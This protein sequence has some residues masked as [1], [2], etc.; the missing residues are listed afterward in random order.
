MQLFVSD[1]NSLV[2]KTIYSYDLVN[3]PSVILIYGPSGSGK[4]TM[5]EFLYQR[6]SNKKV[7]AEFINARAFAQRYAYAAQNN[8]LTSFR[9]RYRSP[10]LLFM[11]DLQLL[12]EKTKTI[13]E[14]FYTYEYI[15]E[16]EGKMIIC[17]EADF[18]ALGF[19][20]EGLASRFSGGL[21]LKIRQPSNE[22]I[23]RFIE[24]YL[25]SRNLYMEQ[26]V[27]SALTGMECNLQM[28]VNT[29]NDFIE[30]TG[31]KGTG[32]DLENFQE[33]LSKSEEANLRKLEF[34]NIIRV[35][36]EIMNTTTDDLL[37][38]RRTPGISEARQLAIYVIRLLC[39]C[40]YPEIGRYFSRGHGAMIYACRQME[41]R[42]AGD[43]D[44]K[45][46]FDAI[47]KFFQS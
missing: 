29:I 2:Y 8:L 21:T 12:A 5:L 31:L 4:T 26:E 38:S 37:G 3:S 33:F 10:K 20:G 46:K 17:L 43:S 16:Q 24:Y 40:S 1:F 13:G 30:F 35:T 44:L 47:N 27:I 15:I 11:D 9:E 25:N 23:E 19:L 34:C 14:L 39:K 41:K 36:A 7:S 6:I 18:P 22:E 45:R 32:F 42:I 28:V